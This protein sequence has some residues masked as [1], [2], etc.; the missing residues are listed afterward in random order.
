MSLVLK[1]ISPSDFYHKKLRSQRYSQNS[2]DVLRT[3]G[4]KGLKGTIPLNHKHE[5][6]VK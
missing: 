1:N 6:R 2:K 3:R 4:M 5:D